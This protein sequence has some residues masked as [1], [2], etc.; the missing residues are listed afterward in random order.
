VV[1]CLCFTGICTALVGVLGRATALV[2]VALGGLR[3]GG[4][5]LAD[6]LRFGM[7]LVEGLAAAA[8]E[9]DLA[10]EVSVHSSLRF[11]DDLGVGVVGVGEDGG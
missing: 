9:E 10:E 3:L 4:D 6:S 8:F 2:M 11:E 5:K 7:V 1:S